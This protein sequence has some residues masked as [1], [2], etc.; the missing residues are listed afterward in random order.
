MDGLEGSF[1]RP[2]RVRYQAALRPDVSRL[3]IVNYL[4]QSNDSPRRSTPV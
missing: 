2:R 3:P 1:T 4:L